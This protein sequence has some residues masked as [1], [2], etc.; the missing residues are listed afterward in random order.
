MA[1]DLTV[2]LEDRPGQLAALGEA[3]G[4]AGI[5]I[6]GVAG[7]QAGGQGVIHV[8][9]EDAEAARSA[10][11]AAGFS[12]G[13]AR[14]VLVVECADRPGELGSVA[15]KV[16]DAGVNITLA[17]LATG[18]RLVLGVDDLEAARAVLG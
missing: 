5:N 7:V 14:E 17:Y 18:T 15:R 3:L 11:Q 2:N 12:P 1:F 13:E 4:G 6:G 10:L 9:V 8:V 16:A